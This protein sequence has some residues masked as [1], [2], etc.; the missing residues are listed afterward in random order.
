ML[1]V[2]ILT[3]CILRNRAIELVIG[4]N[5]VFY[6]PKESWFLDEKIEEIFKRWNFINIDDFNKALIVN[7]IG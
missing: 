1:M 2:F 3:S 4:E 7:Q 6:L 5:G